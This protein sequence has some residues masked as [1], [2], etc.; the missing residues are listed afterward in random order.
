LSKQQKTRV[1]EELTQKLSALKEQKSGL[2]GEAYR[3]AEK[4]DKLNEQVNSLRAEIL[5][6]RGERDRVNEK[7]KELKQQRNEMTTKIHE[8]IEEIKKLTQ[9]NK[10]L[11]KKKPSRSHQA[12]QKEVESI[13]WK[14][15]TT[16]L[17]LQEDK[18]L[19]E[20][21][22]QLE[23]QLNVHR[24]LEQLTQ[25]IA[26]LRTEV[27]ALKTEN[28]LRHQELT[29]NAKQSQEIH[30]NMLERIEES[31]KLK[32][33]ADTIHKQFLEAKEKTRPLQDE[34][35]QIANQIR[36]L[37]EEIQEEEDRE[38]RQSQDALR[39]TLEKQAREKLKRGEKLS[40]EEFQL[41]AEKGIAAED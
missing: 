3:W 13:D 19:V 25:K 31:K 24:K 15:Q 23:T 37:N 39:E 38:K 1:I 2:D 14:I 33:E 11:E 40:W 20:K 16:S 28:Q 10:A 8:K 22:K 30:R 9:E 27:K 32:N 4:R 7:V 21:V 6:L 5:V 12:L 26:E 36:Q 29:K 18:E 35:T 17:T 41:L 34:I